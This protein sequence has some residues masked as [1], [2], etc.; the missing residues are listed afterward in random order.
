MRTGL[1]LLQWNSRPRI[2]DGTGDFVRTRPPPMVWLTSLCQDNS[3][4]HISTAHRRLSNRFCFHEAH[5]F[6]DR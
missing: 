2:L 4:D 3:D 1:L 6:V 5:V